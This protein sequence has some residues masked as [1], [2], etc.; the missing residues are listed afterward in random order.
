MYDVGKDTTH[1]EETEVVRIKYHCGLSL[2][3]NLLTIALK[4]ATYMHKHLYRII[5]QVW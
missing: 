3:L 5:I 4:V 1:V 2:L